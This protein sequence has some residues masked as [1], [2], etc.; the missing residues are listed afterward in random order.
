MEHRSPVASDVMGSLTLEMVICEPFCSF[1]KLLL[2]T[3][4][5]GLIPWHRGVALVGDARLTLRI[6]GLVVLNEVDEIRGAVVLDGRGGN[7][8]LVRQA[9]SPAGAYSQTGW[10]RACRRGCRTAARSFTVPV[11]V[12]IWLSMVIS[13]PVAR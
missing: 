9:C 3:T 2:A 11:V 7:Q 6:V 12:S 10:E 8:R 13:L 5:P 4:S 1:S